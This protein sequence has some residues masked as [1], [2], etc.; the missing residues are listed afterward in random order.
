MLAAARSSSLV[1]AQEGKLAQIDQRSR[2][3]PVD[4]GIP[5][6]NSTR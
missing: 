6:V 3:V 1:I 2:I 5:T 4:L